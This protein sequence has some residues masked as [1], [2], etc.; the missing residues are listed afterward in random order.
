MAD[1][2][3]ADVLFS[4]L[5]VDVPVRS[6]PY[7]EEGVVVSADATGVQV[8]L[9][10]FHPDWKY[11]PCS[12]SRPAATAGYPPAG[13]RCLVVFAGPNQN[14]PWITGFDGWPA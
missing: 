7:P 9:P 10:L 11:G 1:Q 8:Q 13:T 12:W 14:R 2:D 5:K 3:V 6:H 4:L